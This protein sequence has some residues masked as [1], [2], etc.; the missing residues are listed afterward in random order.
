MDPRCQMHVV[1]KLINN[2]NSM[3]PDTVPVVFNGFSYGRKDELA[4]DM[5]PRACRI[6]VYKAGCLTVETLRM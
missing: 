4:S 6:A 2:L 1:Q 5:G 3:H